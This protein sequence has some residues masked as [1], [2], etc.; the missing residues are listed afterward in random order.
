MMLRLFNTGS[1]DHAGLL[2]EPAAIENSTS[3][4][5]C[6]PFSPIHAGPQRRRY[7]M[8]APY[9]GDVIVVLTMTSS[10]QSEPKYDHQAER[11]ALPVVEVFW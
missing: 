8:M 7:E 10:S 11:R 1:R 3:V 6:A 4:S 2:S 5:P 9:V